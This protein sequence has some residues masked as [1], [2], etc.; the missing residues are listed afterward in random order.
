MGI[1]GDPHS[2]N[3]G[4]VSLSQATECGTIYS[5]QELKDIAA[6]V[7]RHDARLHLDGA[8]FANALAAMGASPA[9]IA[10]EIA[11][12]AISF[13]IAKNGGAF[14]DLV[15]L[16]DIEKAEEFR[17][18]QMRSGHLLAKHR[19]ISAQALASLRDGLWLEL[20]TR[21]NQQAAVLANALQSRNFE[22]VFDVKTNLV[23]VEIDSETAD[24]LQCQD[25]I[26]KLYNPAAF[27][28]EEAAASGAKVLRLVTSW[29]TTEDDI[30]RCLEALGPQRL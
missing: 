24:R 14:Y 26:V 5:L 19:F 6:I 15:V 10:A 21:A 13:G 29:Q 8:R 22:A 20:A 1:P 28:R 12:D 2:P 7:R 17:F 11:P 23:F 3:F 25:Q 4:L 16:F 27:D 30:S 9:E 18:R